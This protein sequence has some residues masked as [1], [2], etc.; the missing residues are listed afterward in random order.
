MELLLPYAAQRFPVDRVDRELDLQAFKSRLLD[1]LF[2][3]ILLSG[4]A[5][6]G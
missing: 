1:P 4:P 2:G 5:F 3:K 6:K